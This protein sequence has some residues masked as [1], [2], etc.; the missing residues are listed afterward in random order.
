MEYARSVEWVNENPAGAAELIASNGIIESPAVAEKA[1]PHCNIVCLTGQ[2]MFDKLSGYL[3]VLA[4][5]NPES[6]GGQLPGDDFYY[7]I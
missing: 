1:L 4:E 3:Q 5:A 7:G 6:V 2:E